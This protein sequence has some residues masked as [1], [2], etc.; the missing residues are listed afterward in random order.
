MIPVSSVFDQPT[1]HALLDHDPLVQSYRSFFS[2]LDWSLVE[3]WERQQSTHRR[4]PLH[5]ESSYLKAFLLRIRE[6]LSSFVHL[7]RFLLEHPLLI[8]EFDFHLVLDASAPYG[9]D[10]ERSLPCRF[11]FS[12]KLRTLDPAL[13]HDLLRGTVTALLDEIPGLGETVAF[14]VKHLYGWV[15]ENNP[16][17]SAPDRADK[18]HRPNGDPDCRLGVKRSTN[19]EQPDG[20]SKEKKEALWGYGSGVAA[21]TIPEYGDV[22]LA[23]YTQPFNHADPTYFEPLYERVVR[24]LGQAPTNITADAAFDAWYVY[25]KVTPHGGMAAVPKNQHGHVTVERD[26]DGVPRCSMGLRM[27][28]M[29]RFRHTSGYQA[30]MYRCP[31]LFPVEQPGACCEHTQFAKKGCTKHLNIEPGGLLRVTLDRDSPLYQAVYRQRTSC[32]R[33]NSQAKELGIEH[34]HV[35][36]R[37]SVSNL[38]TLIYICINTRTLYRAKTINRGLLQMI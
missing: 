4:P 38:N 7:R 9:F 10:P 17:A 21:S 19:Q 14:D 34:P 13:L 3:Q 20:S 22:V 30:Q 35:R 24:A 18:T 28:P 32:E 33:I 8:L 16:R 37:S 5:C 12:Q 23:E 2:L 29:F 26:A 15:K 25:Q 6:G 36:N 27:H 31:L 1:L 11:W